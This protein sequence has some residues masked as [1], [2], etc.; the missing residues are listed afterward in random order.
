M[1]WSDAFRQYL[2]RSSNFDRILLALEIIFLFWLG[3]NLCDY[4]L[5]S[6]HQVQKFGFRALLGFWSVV[7]ATFFVVMFIFVAYRLAFVVLVF[8]NPLRVPTNKYPS[9]IEDAAN[10][11]RSQ[12]TVSF[13]NIG[14]ALVRFFKF[15][16]FQGVSMCVCY[17]FRL[18]FM[19]CT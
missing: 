5:F 12:I 15:Y 17:V 4:L 19:S 2:L 3:S 9:V 16:R 10:I 1:L 18:C 6:R 11:N 7:D 8:G 14:F 13:F